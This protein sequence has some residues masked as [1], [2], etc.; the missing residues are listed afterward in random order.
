MEKFYNIEREPEFL[1][2]LGFIRREE[3][4]CDQTRSVWYEKKIQSFDSQVSFIVQIEFE[5]N[6]YDDPSAAYIDNCIYRF[7]S[8]YVRVI[9]RQ[10]EK[11]DNRTYDEDTEIPREIDR[12]EL[13]ISTSTQL[14][15]FCNMLGDRTV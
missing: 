6:L 3:D 10:M 7:N 9:D 13:N 1:V 14:K 4:S 15:S 12:C 11:L 8:V 5:L 2:K